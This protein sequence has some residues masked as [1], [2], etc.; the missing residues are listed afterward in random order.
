MGHKKLT[1]GETLR[2]IKKKL[3]F[4]GENMISFV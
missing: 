3:E 2:Y 4:I 1:N